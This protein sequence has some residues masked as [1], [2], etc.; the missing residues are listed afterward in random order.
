MTPAVGQSVPRKEGIGKATGA[1]R[2]A[3]DLGFPG[4]LYGRTVRTTIPCGTIDSVRLDF[5]RSGFTVV[6]HTDV[7]GRN[8]VALIEDDQPFLVEREVRHGAE[9]VLLLAHADREVLLGARVAIACTPG[10][11]VLDVERSA[12]VLKAIDIDKGDVEPALAGAAYVVEGTY[13]TGHQEHVYIEPN[14]VVAV[15][16]DGG[17]TVYGSIQCPFYVHRALV[18]LLGSAVR[19]VRVVQTETGGGF[20]GKEEYPSMIAGHAAL[21]ALKSGRPVKLA[22]DREEDLLATTKRHPSIV[23]HRTG[24]TSDGRLVAMDIEVILDGGAYVTLSPVVLSRGA[25]HSAGPYRCPNTRIRARAMFTNTPPN[26]AFRGFG[27]P[28]TQFAMEVHMD[29][30][31]DALGVDPLRLRERNAL[32]PG[33]T[34]ATGQTLG[35]DCGA[36]AVLREGARRSGFR[37]KRRAAASTGRGVGLSLFYHGSGFTGSGELKLASRAALEVTG[38]GVRILTSSTEIGQGTRTMHAQIVADAL[39]I[40]YEQVH[41]A[42]PDTALVPDSGPTVASRTCMVVGK[43][44]E[45]CAAELRHAMGGLAPD[46][47]FRRHGPLRVER[48]YEQ[49]EW[50][51]WDEHRY[52]GDAYATYAWGCSVAEVELDPVTSAVRPLRLTAVADIGR[53]IHPA[54]A[55]GQIEGGTAQAIGWALTEQVVMENGVM[56]N[57]QLTNYTIPTT[58]DTPAIDVCLLETPYPGGPFGAKGL[59][60]LPIDGPA[61]AI[62][63]AIRSLG[64]DVRSIPRP[65]KWSAP[66]APP[67]RRETCASRSTGRRAISTPIR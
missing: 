40:P 50:I 63:N 16:D 41:V 64:P 49:P 46:E 12:R 3:D 58:L 56:K 25:I 11:P 30:I 22:Y 32:R 29:R 67:R 60:E 59:G 48:E 20:G 55:R 52:R 54:L 7:P 4:M 66:A 8:V 28:Q 19:R 26:G 42:P 17:M 37:R 14:A 51:R 43:I 45:R 1:A 23:R 65:P 9:P 57:A 53:A 33:D 61:P 6:D 13:R 36:L 38:D 10:E 62:V 18:E 47:Y 39:G 21:L 31:A 15:P 2:Y 44:L 35:S 27:A 34:T 5:D 24:L